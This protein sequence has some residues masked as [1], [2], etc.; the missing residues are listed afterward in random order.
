MHYNV[1]M[2]HLEQFQ[3]IVLTIIAGLVNPFVVLRLF[4][5]RTL[6]SPFKS[7]FFFFLSLL[8]CEPI[9]VYFCLYEITFDLSSNVNFEVECLV[10]LCFS[11]VLVMLDSDAFT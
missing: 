3:D 6:I 2:D 1:I 4:L 9:Y 10:K 7:F 11:P 5:Q 8:L